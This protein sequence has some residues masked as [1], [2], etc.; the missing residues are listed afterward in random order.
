MTD[1]FSEIYDLIEAAVWPGGMTLNPRVNPTL[2]PH[3]ASCP[4]AAAR[5]GARG[6]IGRRW[7]VLPSLEAGGD[8]RG[9]GGQIIPG[10]KRKPRAQLSL[11]A[12]KFC[13]GGYPG[14]SLSR[15]SPF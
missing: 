6:I 10:T 15:R 14:V 12:R 9:Y 11:R 7:Q 13:P 3:L 2:N 8:K 5:R 1:K 4:S